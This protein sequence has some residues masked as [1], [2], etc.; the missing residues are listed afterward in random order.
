[1]IF[2][3]GRWSYVLLFFCLIQYLYCLNRWFQRFFLFWSWHKEQT[4]S[5]FWWIHTLKSLLIS[6]TYHCFS[7]GSSELEWR[8]RGTTGGA[9]WILTVIFDKET[10]PNT[11]FRK[12]LRFQRDNS[13]LKCSANISDCYRRPLCCL[14]NNE[15]PSW[16]VQNGGYEIRYRVKHNF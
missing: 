7:F 5:I 12:V 9:S 13:L 2:Y 4:T 11:S 8:G 14:L 3:F 16:M 1:M 15:I 6:K 10:D